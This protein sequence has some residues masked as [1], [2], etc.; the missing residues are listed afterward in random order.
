MTTP[1]V[2]KAPQVFAKTAVKV[3]SPSLSPLFLSF[4]FRL[5]LC[6]HAR[7]TRDQGL[8]QDLRPWQREDVAAG[9][10]SAARPSLL[11]LRPRAAARVEH[12]EG[13]SFADVLSFS[14]FHAILVGFEGVR[15]EGDGHRCHPRPHCWLG[16]E[17]EFFSCRSPD[18]DP[19]FLTRTRVR[20]FCHTNNRPSTG[21]RGG[22]PRSTTPSRRPRSKNLVC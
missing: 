5:F 18:L 8:L 11:S 21:T 20:P 16:L 7:R 9:S 6:P 14:L 2:I 13:E 22:R 19:H 3:R 12:S 17:G 15:D 4:R 1:A 10:R